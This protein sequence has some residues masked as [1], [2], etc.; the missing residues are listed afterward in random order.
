MHF[1]IAFVLLIAR[2]ILASIPTAPGAFSPSVYTGVPAMH[3]F[4][5]P[6]HKCVFV[7]KV[8]NFTFAHL[9][10]GQYA[11]SVE[12]DPTTGTQVPLTLKSNAFCAAGVLLANGQYLLVGGNAPLPDV[13]PTVGD[14]FRSIRYLNHPSDGSR[15]G[16]G[17]DEYKW[18][19]DS[20]RWYPTTILLN[21]SMVF[22][23]SGSRNGLDPR[24][25]TN[26]NPTYEI[27]NENGFPMGTSYPCK[28]LIDNQPTF[29]YPIV[30]L[31]SDGTVLICVARTCEIHDPIANTTLRTLP[32]IPGAVRTY[33]NA[34]GSALLPLTSFNN[35]KSDILICGGGTSQDLTSPSDPTC[36]RINPYDPAAQWQVDNMGQGRVMGNLVLHPNGNITIV[37]GANQGS[38]GYNLA[39]N[40][41]QDALAYN[42]QQPIGQR[43]VK[44]A[45]S[46]IPRLYHS[47]TFIDDQGLTHIAGSNPN[48]QPVLVPNDENPYPTEFRSEIYRTDCQL[49]SSAWSKRPQ[50]VTLT[51]NVWPTLASPGGISQKVSFWAPSRG[52]NLMVS[53]EYGGFSTHGLTMA[54]RLIHLDHTGFIPN[55]KW[56]VQNISVTPPPNHNVTPRGWYRLWIVVDCVNSD[57]TWIQVL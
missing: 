16:A 10:N 47:V 15:D 19:L 56:G 41:V 45:R 35:W 14:G 43:I 6:N 12:Y 54:N 34:G 42:H 5:L 25:S 40:P 4:C 44:T 38:E 7:D 24:N 26:N 48:E 36:V 51:N 23:V 9:S 17:W 20:P 22:V 52:S 46:P 49:D 13:D 28:L 50:N 18:Q 55:S 8:E 37:N 53:L 3:A 21:N 2:T 57:A 1:L 33:P 39:R 29:M 31:L 32:T 30:F 27:L 11:Y